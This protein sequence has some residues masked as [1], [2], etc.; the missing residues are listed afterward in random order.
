MSPKTSSEKAQTLLSE[1]KMNSSNYQ[2]T[3]TG[4]F[5]PSS[6]NRKQCGAT[7]F[8]AGKPPVQSSGISL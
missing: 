4:H 6:G 8:E 2:F 5:R 1:L 3:Q 7:N